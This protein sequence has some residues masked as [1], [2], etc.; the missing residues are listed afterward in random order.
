MTPERFPFRFRGRTLSI[1]GVEL[2]MKLVDERDEQKYRGD[3][4]EDLAIFLK[5]PGSATGASGTFEST[6]TSAFGSVPHTNGPIG[7]STEVKSSD[8]TWKLEA[9]SR[10]DVTAGIAGL[11]K[12]LRNEVTVNGTK[13]YHLKPDVIEDIFVVCHY[14]VTG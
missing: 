9:E 11:H 4:G 1:D 6:T 7:V 3:D 13:R 10:P 2:F 14:S 12:D 8:A 5:P